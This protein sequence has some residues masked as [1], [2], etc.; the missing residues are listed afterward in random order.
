MVTQFTPGVD[1]EAKF[2]WTDRTHTLKV[3]WAEGSPEP[4]REGRCSIRSRSVQQEAKIA[5]GADFA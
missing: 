2:T 3:R 4:P 1:L 5:V